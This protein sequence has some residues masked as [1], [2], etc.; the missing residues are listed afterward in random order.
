MIIVIIFFVI[1]YAGGC[2]IKFI[3]PR[4]LHAKSRL[5]FGIEEGGGASPKRD[6]GELILSLIESKFSFLKGP[7]CLIGI[8]F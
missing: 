8:L 4:T 7:K 3:L 1:F 6:D 5:F 2:I